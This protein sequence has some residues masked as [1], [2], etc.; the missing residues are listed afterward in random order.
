MWKWSG[1][2]NH[3]DITG[4][5]NYLTPQQLTQLFQPTN[6]HRPADH[7]RY[8]REICSKWLLSSSLHDIL[9]IAFRRWAIVDENTAQAELKCPS[10][11]LADSMKGQP[12]Q[13]WYQQGLQWEEALHRVDLATGE[14]Y[15]HTSASYSLMV[16]SWTSSIPN[17]ITPQ[18]R[19]IKSVA[20][21]NS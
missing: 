14:F 4:P 7:C 13:H 5:S 21:T 12:L 16:G 8:F 15:S 18:P 10:R 9:L 20:C 19:F 11:K 6:S 2:T 3:E 1:P 17:D